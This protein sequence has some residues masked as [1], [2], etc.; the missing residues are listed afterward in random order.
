[1]DIVQNLSF[2]WTDIN[3]QF[4]VFNMYTQDQ[5]MARIKKLT[6]ENIRLTIHKFF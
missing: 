1:M 2:N 5:N 4:Q 6:C 3:L